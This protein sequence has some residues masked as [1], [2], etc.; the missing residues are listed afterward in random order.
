MFGPR[1]WPWVLLQGLFGGA[2]RFGSDFPGF[3]VGGFG[4]RIQ[5]PFRLQGLVPG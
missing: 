3:V 5:G 2:A 4:F 1:S